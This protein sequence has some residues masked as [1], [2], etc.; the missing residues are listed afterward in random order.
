MRPWAACKSSGPAAC[1]F[2]THAVPVGWFHLR[3][4][5]DQPAVERH[6]GIE[7]AKR[8]SHHSCRE[9][10]PGHANSATGLAALECGRHEPAPAIR[11]AQL[12]DGREPYQGGSDGMEDPR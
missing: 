9:T 5:V 6:L 4:L 1:S 8:V 10:N 3:T 7:R 12:T 11:I 2:V